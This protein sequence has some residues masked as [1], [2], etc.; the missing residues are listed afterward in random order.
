[1]GTFPTQRAA[2]AALGV[3]PSTIS[4][5]AK[6]PG[7]LERVGRDGRGKRK[8]VQDEKGNWWPS[9][10]ALAIHKKKSKQ[11]VSQAAKRRERRG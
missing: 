7:G 9:Y 3:N 5:A 1:M 6:V 10:T 8:P 2:A 4:R 11:A